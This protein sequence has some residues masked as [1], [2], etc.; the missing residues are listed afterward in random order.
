MTDGLVDKGIDEDERD[1]GTARR[2]TRTRQWVIGGGAVLALAAGGLAITRP[3]EGSDDTHGKAPAAGVTIAPP[4]GERVEPELSNRLAIG[5]LPEDYR[6]QW[7]TDGENGVFDGLGEPMST[8]VILAGPTATVTDGPWLSVTVVLL[9]KFDRRQFEPIDFV[10]ASDGLDLRINELDG[11]FATNDFD[12]SVELAFGPMNEGYVVTMAAVGLTQAEMVAVATELQL[13]ESA[14]EAVAWPQFGPKVSELELQP[15]ASFEQPNSGFGGGPGMQF[16]VLSGST[17]TATS[18]S[19]ATADFEMISLTND[20]VIPGLDMLELVRFITQDAQDVTIHGQPAVMG[21]MDERFGGSVI[22]WA[23]GG[24]SVVLFTM[25]ELDDPVALAE[26]VK[27]LDEGAWADLATEAE[28][29]QEEGDFSSEPSETWLIG[30]GELEDSTTWLVEGAVDEDGNAT[31]C[32]A[33]M[34]NGSSSTGCNSS[35]KVEAPA[36]VSIGTV[37]ADGD[38]APAYVAAVPVG[39]VGAILRFTAGDGTV[40]ET[41]IHEV[42]PDWPVLAAAIA[43]TEVGT[44]QIVAADGTAMDTVEITDDDLT[45]VFG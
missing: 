20:A 6:V 1:D 13:S 40:V 3:W 14:S 7:V 19:Y 24:R 28:A 32:T 31:W 39:T 42:R 21:S 16:G 29:N 30:A 35:G 11:V 27:V 36:I 12:D 5:E 41:S 10:A 17:P 37:G 22:A 25:G 8:N 2:N 4:A 9:D 18:V 38:F 43:V 23:E 34:D 33:A 44:L 26:S 45:T 15:L